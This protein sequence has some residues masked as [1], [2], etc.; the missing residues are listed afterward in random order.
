M[1][2]ARP[3]AAAA[4]DRNRHDVGVL[5][6]G[7]AAGPGLGLLE[8]VLAV[9]LDEDADRA[10]RLRASSCTVRSA[11]RSASPRRTGKVPPIRRKAP[12]GRGAE[13][14][15]LGHVADRPRL[16]GA[17]RGDVPQ[18]LVVRDEHAPARCAGTCSAPSRASAAGRE[19]RR[20]P[21]AARASRSGRRGRWPA[22]AG[23]PGQLDDPSTTCSAREVAGVD[24]LRVGRRRGL[25]GVQ[26][27]AL[28][29]RALAP[30]RRVSP[31]SAARRGGAH[32]ASAATRKTLRSASGQTTDAG[33][34]PLEH[35]VARPARAAGAHRRPHLR[36]PGDGADVAR[37]GLGAQVGAVRRRLA[38]QRGQRRRRRSGW[39][40]GER[41]PP[42]ARGTSRRCRRSAGRAAGPAGGRRCSCRRRP[43]RRS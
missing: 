18:R 33:V 2:A 38:D 3:P 26:A 25:L 34:A 32:A 14:L 28:D 5:D 13:Q 37:D 1:R 31:R 15:R 4:A 11:S 35:G 41:A 19:Q 24:Q 7:D 42:S 21:R 22:V 36:V 9:A 17:D 6:D 39:R 12:N 29:D 27:V 16:G 40:R 23:V 30:L 10:A 8:A 43:V 20:G